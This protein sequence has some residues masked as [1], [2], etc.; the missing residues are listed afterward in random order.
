MVVDVPFLVSI[1]YVFGQHFKTNRLTND[2][3]RQVPLR[4]KDI[5]VLIGVFIDDG[6]ILIEEFANRKVDIRRF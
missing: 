2:P 5:T 4:V 6:L 3:C 1:G